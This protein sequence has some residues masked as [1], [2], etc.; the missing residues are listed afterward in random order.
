MTGKALEQTSISS[1]LKRHR[2]LLA[3]CRQAVFAEFHQSE[4]FKEK[5]SLHLCDTKKGWEEE[6]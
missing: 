6:R 3:S 4:D 5:D 2:K 1:G